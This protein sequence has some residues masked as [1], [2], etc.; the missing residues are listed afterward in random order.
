MDDAGVSALKSSACLVA[1]IARLRETLRTVCDRV[2]SHTKRL[3]ESLGIPRNGGSS[4]S[5]H[6]VNL[7][8]EALEAEL[9]IAQR[10]LTGSIEVMDA[11]VKR[12]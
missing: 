6:R 1:E 10:A 9:D 3:R 2:G 5:Y 8:F 12:E 11:D 7:L 4:P